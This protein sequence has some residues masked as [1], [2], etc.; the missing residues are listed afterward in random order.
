MSS[1]EST[2]DLARHVEALETI[3][4]AQLDGHRRMLACMERKREAIRHADIERMTAICKE[5]APLLSRIS[6]LEKHRLQVIGLLTGALRP[7]ASKPLT[8]MEVASLATGVGAA[9]LIV[10]A[11]ELRALVKRVHHA[12]SIV[13]V[14]MDI[15]NKHMAGIVQVM[16]SALSRAQIYGRGGRMLTG[17]QLHSAI[18]LKS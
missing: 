7:G 18:D 13:R 17:A 5:E 12:T 16:Q 15:L 14:A 1:R 10:A 8:V 4:R 3:L 11:D 9:G 2:I 6:E